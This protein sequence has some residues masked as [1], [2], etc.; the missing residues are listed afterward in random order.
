MKR[1]NEKGSVH[2]KQRM[3]ELRDRKMRLDKSDA[4]VEWS[5]RTGRNANEWWKAAQES[6]LTN[7]SNV[8]DRIAF[9]RGAK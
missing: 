1:W 3:S 7:N 6:G 9:L 8:K 4:I 2:A 5:V